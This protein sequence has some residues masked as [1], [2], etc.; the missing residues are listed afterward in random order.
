MSLRAHVA[1]QS[2]ANSAARVAVAVTV[3]C[4][5]APRPSTAGLVWAVV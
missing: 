5:E 1:K 3:R 4:E 2:H